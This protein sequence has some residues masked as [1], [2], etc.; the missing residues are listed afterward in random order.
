[1]HIDWVIPC[2]F[3]EVHDNLG[4]LIGAGIDTLWVPGFPANVQVVMAIRLLATA[5]ELGDDHQHTI[6]NIVRGP[7]DNKVNEQSAEFAIGMENARD[8]WLNGL[9]MNSVVA[10]PAVSQGTYTVEHQ[11][12]GST[13][14]VP[15]HVV[16]GQPGP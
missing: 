9:I 7:G 11:V 4:T 1:M 12:D 5:D 14:S 6:S 3:S 13:S 15:I 10:F 8:D 16:Q 2:R